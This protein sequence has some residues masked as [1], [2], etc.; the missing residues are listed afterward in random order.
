[1]R[2]ILC[3]V[4]LCLYVLAFNFYLWELTHQDILT[5]RETKL[6]YNYMTAGMILFCFA[7]I[8]G[9]IVYDMHRQLNEI[10]ILT[11][12]AHFTIL[13]LINH[14]IITKPLPI[15]FIFNG[16]VFVVTVLITL[17]AV[18]HDFIKE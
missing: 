7:D 10:C 15:L 4:V 8:K 12:L 6:F 16:L 11:V 3:I 18:K 9:G 14:L 5:F 2:V 17:A 13:I 1:M